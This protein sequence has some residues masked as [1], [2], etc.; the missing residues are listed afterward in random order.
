M[1]DKVDWSQFQKEHYFD[2]ESFFNLRE[3]VSNALEKSGAKITGGGIGGGAADIW[4]ELDG[5][6]FY[7]QVKPKMKGTQQ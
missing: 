5:S 7:L 3:Y 4:F 6:E 1:N 2:V